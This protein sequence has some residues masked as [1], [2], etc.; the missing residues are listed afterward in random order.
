VKLENAMQSPAGALAV[1]AGDLLFDARELRLTRQIGD[2]WPEEYLAMRILREE[3]IKFE[4][5]K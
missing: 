1:R 4:N 2:L 5:Q 3:Q